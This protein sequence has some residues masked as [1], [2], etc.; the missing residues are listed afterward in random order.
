[1]LTSS[2][3]YAA[4]PIILLGG[5]FFLIISGAKLFSLLSSRPA[6][7]LGNVSYGIYLLQELIMTLVLRRILTLTKQASTP[8][9]QPQTTW[10]DSPGTRL[11]QFISAKTAAPRLAFGAN[12]LK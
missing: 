12:M 3:V 1:M 8:L 2:H 10:L 6:R 7:R 4:G 5:A 11:S 9:A